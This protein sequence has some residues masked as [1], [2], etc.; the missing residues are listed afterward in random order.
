MSFSGA[1]NRAIL[2]NSQQAVEKLL[3]NLK[4]SHEVQAKKILVPMKRHRDCLEQ[5]IVS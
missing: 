4:K 1:I 3:E 2:V 5:G